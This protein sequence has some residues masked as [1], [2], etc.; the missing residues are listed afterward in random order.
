[1]SSANVR[2]LDALRHFKSALIAF[3][4]ESRVSLDS[5]EME[6]R[7]FRNWLERDQLSYWRS[8][9]KRGQEMVAMAKSELFRRQLSQSEAVSDTDQKEALRKAKRRL[10]EAEEKVEL[11]KKWIPV[12]EHAIS[13]YHSQSQ[14][15][16]DRLS[17][18]FLGTLASLDRMIAAID[19]YASLAPPS[20]PVASTGGPPT[21]PVSAGSSTGPLGRGAGPKAPADEA[22]TGDD[23]VVS[24]VATPSPELPE[25]HRP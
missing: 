16:G 6:I 9:I 25:D 23:P 11:I 24:S 8:Q 7:Q 1:M 15:L 18:G 4:D 5:V 22:R 14:P 10:Q 3:A 12:L 20:A 13:E 2:S 21:N 17:G 19:A